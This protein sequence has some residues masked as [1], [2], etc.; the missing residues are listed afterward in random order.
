MPNVIALQK[1]GSLSI[2]GFA[3]NLTNGFIWVGDAGNLPVEVS[4]SEAID[5]R[6]AALLVA[7]TNITLTYDD[8]LNTLTIDATGGGAAYTAEEAQDA[9][10][11]ILVDSSTITFTY[12]DGVPSITAA[13]I[14]AS[15]T[16]IKLANMAQNTIKGRISAG[17]GTPE[18]LTATQVRTLINVESG[19]TND[20][21]AAEILALLITVDG[22]SSG[23]DADLLDGLSSLA[24][25]LASH[26]HAVGDITAL[27][28]YI[29]D[30]VA[31]LLVAGTDIT[32]TYN[33]GANTLTIAST[34]SGG[35]SAADV[36]CLYN[37]EDLLIVTN[38]VK[39]GVDDIEFTGTG[40]LIIEGTGRLA[41]I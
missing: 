30:V 28:E 5:D 27:Q 18:D 22:A 31:N 32:L 34:A 15:L 24:F 1:I 14:N 7:G 16:N 26:S 6:V 23:L 25:A 8:V 9:I 4:F 10:G 13:V 19:A 12:N 21:T 2:T 17:A 37:N 11:T 33:D 38:T 36:K 41:I 3:A 40:N 35:G 20:L 39:V 29:E